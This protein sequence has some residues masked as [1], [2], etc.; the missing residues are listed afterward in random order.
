ME[1]MKRKSLA[2]ADCAS[3]I[4]LNAFVAFVSCV[5]Q[6]H[7][8]FDLDLINDIGMLLTAWIVTARVCYS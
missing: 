8:F 4:L 3:N 5:R 1:M 2:P 6:R 7:L